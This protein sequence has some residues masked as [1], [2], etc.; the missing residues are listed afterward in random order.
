MPDLGLRFE[1]IRPLGSGGMADVWLVEDRDS[2]GCVV[3]KIARSETPES[4]AWLRREYELGSRLDHPNIVRVHELFDET[5]VTFMTMEHLGGG[6]IG[7]LAGGQPERIR[8]SLLETAEALRYAHERGIVHRDLKPSNVLLDKSGE[9]HVGDFGIADFSAD[10][11]RDPV[12][13]GGS[14]G[15]VS[16]Q[17]LSGEPASPADDI[18]AFGA[19]AYT[20]LAGGPPLGTDPSDDAIRG[21]SP[22]PLRSVTPVPDDLRRLIH[23]MLAKNPAERPSS[24]A[25]VCDALSTLRAATAEHTAPPRE[26]TPPPTVKLVPP[27]RPD[28]IRPIEPAAVDDESATSQPNRSRILRIATGGLFA[29]LAVLV[30]VVFGVLPRWVEDRAPAGGTSASSIAAESPLTIPPDDENPMAAAES[31]PR[32]SAEQ[33]R[34]LF[35]QRLRAL[36]GLEAHRW[37]AW[38]FSVARDFGDEGARQ[39]GGAEFSAA[40]A[41]YRRGIDQLAAIEATIPDVVAAAVADGEK[42]LAKGDSA[43]ATEAFELAIRLDPSNIRA[44]QGH[45]R[46]QVLDQVLELM[47]RGA[48]AERTGDLDAAAVAYR[49]AAQLD[50]LWTD[51]RDATQRVT[52]AAERRTFSEHM[53]RVLAALDAGNLAIAREAVAD[54]RNMRPGSPEVA[55]ADRRISNEQRRR[56]L[57]TLRAD[58]RQAESAE[59]WAEAVDLY[60]QVLAIDGN[61]AF[62]KTGKRRAAARLELG[63]AIEYHL[64]HPGRLVD[65]DVFGEAISLLERA[66]TIDPRGPLLSG[67]ITRL[68]ALVTRSSIPVPVSLHSDNETQVVIYKVGRLG[69]FSR[70]TLELRPGTYTVVG[71]RPGFRDVRLEITVKPDGPNPPV[72]VRCKE[73]V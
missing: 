19:L 54:A 26:T 8:R 66:R 4:A 72:V 64:G 30:V 48:A 40:E 22:P 32:A 9:A 20:L 7:R 16:P 41:A 12:T 46:A 24:M 10:S 27:P 51:A 1:P 69:V 37:E 65:D 35:E 36:V 29:V 61:L 49:R 33:A 21:Q 34:A 39:F 18:Y 53:S 11:D 63:A 58:A 14:R 38:K 57:A 67:Q 56:T 70:K 5:P 15:Y 59:A 71:T 47:D 45:R 68:D 43:A 13:G 42:A 62:A 25:K 6:D 3:A 23:R 73:E 52:A 50:P 28:A 2:G 60:T 44:Q 17:Q 31:D 55:E